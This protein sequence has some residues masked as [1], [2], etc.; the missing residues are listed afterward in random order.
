MKKRYRVAGLALAILVA[1]SLSTACKQ[2]DADKTVQEKRVATQEDY[3][4]KPFRTIM[5]EQKLSTDKKVDTKDIP[6]YR[7]SE[8]LFDVNNSFWPGKDASFVGHFDSLPGNTEAMMA[9]LPTSAMRMR[10]DGSVYVIYD[11]DT[12]YRVF[13]L[14]NPEQDYIATM[15]FPII[16]KELLTHQ[17][18]SDLQVGDSIEKVEKIDPV[19][20]IHKKMIEDVWEMD[21]AGAAGMAEMGRPC[22]SVHYLRDGILKISY[23]MQDDRS[24]VIADMEYS[25]DYV[26]P[27]AGGK[28]ISYKLCEADL[29]E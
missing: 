18:F 26:L 6:V 25:P 1:A 10:E 14:V 12:G 5:E 23:D 29:P 7:E 11:T 27:S 21:P 19:A 15:G 4:L 24:L 9:E 3:C 20:T 28:N 17:D 13:V 8:L 16:V 2:K 22:T